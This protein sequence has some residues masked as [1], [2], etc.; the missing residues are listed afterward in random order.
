MRLFEV[1]D[2]F[3]NDLEMVL[4]NLIG[5]SDDKNASMTLSYEALS[6]IMRN[7]GYGKIDYDGFAKVFD[8]NPSLKSVVKNFDDDGVVLSTETPAENDEEPVDV[9]AGPSVD[10][11]AHSAVAKGL[12]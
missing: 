6:N 4:K 5:R 1:E 11:M 3:G 2:H 10:Q 7:M 12:Q 9:P 8:S